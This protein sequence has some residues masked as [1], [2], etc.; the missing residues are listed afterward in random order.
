MKKKWKKPEIII[1]I[2]TKTPENLMYLGD[3]DTGS[4]TNQYG[5]CGTGGQ[6]SL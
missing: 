2:N 5:D 3:C 4:T 1:L 6:C